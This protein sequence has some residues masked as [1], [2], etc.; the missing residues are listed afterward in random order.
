MEA[1]STAMGSGRR[2]YKYVIQFIR[3]IAQQFKISRGAARVGILSFAYNTNRLLGLSG[4][5][6]LEQI[7]NAVNQMRTLSGRRRLGNALYYAKRYLFAGRPQCGRRRILIVLTIG[8]STDQVQRSALSLQGAGVE[9]FMIG[10]GS[11]RS[12][13]LSKVAAD[14]QHIFMVGFTQLYTIVK[15]LRDRICRYPGEL[16][17]VLLI[18]S[19]PLNNC[20]SQRGLR[21]FK[22]LFYF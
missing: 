11:V 10:V 1:T 16:V 8:S 9:I 19:S 7:Y 6:T 12:G 21:L 3:K 18:L 2:H 20:K 14:T 17:L 13:I 5:Y 22:F 4:S 15:S